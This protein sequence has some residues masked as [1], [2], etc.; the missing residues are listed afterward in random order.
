MADLV[1]NDEVNAYLG[2]SGVDYS[3]EIKRASRRVEGK[4]GPVIYTS[5]TEKHDGGYD[6]FLLNYSPLK[7]GSVAITDNETGQTVDSDEYIEDESGVVY[8]KG[9]VWAVGRNRF[10]VTYQ[11]GRVPDTASVPEDIKEATLLLIKAAQSGGTSVVVK[12]KRIG[13][14]SEEYDTSKGGSAADEV[15]EILAPYMGVG[16]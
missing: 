1:T 13:S 7:T 5:Y 14:W 12:A 16:I 15:D 2:T 9:G 4:I 3:T 8:K 6:R 11:A 10:T